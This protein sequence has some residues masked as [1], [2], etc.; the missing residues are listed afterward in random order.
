VAPLQHKLD[1]RVMISG[2]E[3]ARDAAG[4]RAY[5]FNKAMRV[6]YDSGCRRIRSAVP[7]RPRTGDAEVYLVRGW[8][9]A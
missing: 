4:A 2:F 9:P 6:L 3:L 5:H 8:L 7:V 1:Y